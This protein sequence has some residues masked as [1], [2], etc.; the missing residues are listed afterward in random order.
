[1]TNLPKPSS[2]RGNGIWDAAQQGIST[3]ANAVISLLVVTALSMEDYGAYSYA[4]AVTGIAMS[5][6]NAG[7]GGLVV[8]YL[9]EH[10]SQN[11]ALVTAM[12]ISRSALACAGYACAALLALTAGNE[13]V[14]VATLVALVAL[15]GKALEGPEAWFLSQLRSRRTATLR[16]SVTLVAFSARLAAIIFFPSLLVFVALF[17]LEAILS[18]IA[19]LVAYLREPDSPGLSR[20]DIRTSAELI[21][22]SLPLL[23]SGVA[24]QVTLKANVIIVQALLG[25]TSVAVFSVAARISELAYFLPVVFMNSLLPHLMSLRFESED[26]S[27][28]KAMMK[29]AYGRALWAGIGV[30]L[31][32]GVVSAFAIPWI[33]GPEYGDSVPVLAIYL[34]ATPFVF[35]AAV[36]SKW[37]IV[38]KVL[39]A[40]LVRHCIG[41]IVSIG[42]SIALV[43]VAGVTGAAAATVLAYVSASYVAAFFSRLTRGQAILMSS[44]WLYP[45]TLIGRRRAGGMQHRGGRS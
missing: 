19:I 2:V 43:P 10:R 11:R 36:Y 34:C 30:G 38:E 16:V 25:A 8:R 1:M 18:G 31:V 6:M 26:P 7:L 44:A 27:A 29:K 35:M 15:F 33:F 45:L 23:L 42:A 20:P 32:V 12:L 40:S 22:E 17:V 13:V 39:W 4:I 14:L 28:Y 21:R 37:I 41:A 5:I 24:N 9:V 3:L